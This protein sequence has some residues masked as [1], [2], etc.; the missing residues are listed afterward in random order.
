MYMN[1]LF[2]KYTVYFLLNP[3]NLY[4]R[5]N[6]EATLTDFKILLIFYRQY[7]NYIK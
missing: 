5:K 7:L 3:R 2:Y 6:R 4:P 1:S